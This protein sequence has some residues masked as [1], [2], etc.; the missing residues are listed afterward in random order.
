MCRVMRVHRS[1]YY[2]WLKEPES[3]RSKED[4]RLLHLIRESYM[5]SGKVY[6]SPKV[7]K[8]LRE[9][10]ERCGRK[11]VERLMKQAGLR[12]LIGYKKPKYTYG[13]PSIVYPD[14]LEQNFDFTKPDEAWVT[15]IT[16]IST[17]E[18]WLYLAVVMDLFSRM[19]V[20]WSMKLTLHRDLVLDA[21]LM[22]VW[23]RKPENPVIVHSDQ[24]AQY[25]SDD[26]MRFCKEHGLDPSMSRKGN[27]YDNAA[28]ESF[29]SSLK[30]ERIRRRIYSTREDAKS[31][32]FD[33]IELFYNSRRRHSY[34][35][36]VSPQEYESAG[37]GSR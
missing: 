15:D 16:Y 17:Y 4:R 12:A 26:W 1:G 7:Y 20:G 13:V 10:G 23:R 35:G 28:A 5:E 24:G 34:L 19:I 3:Q 25:G 11:R 32:V 9:M 29:F 14:K 2:A 18:G 21:L 22:A 27:C 6:G 33:Y 30:K 8:D 36:Y 31:D 37:I